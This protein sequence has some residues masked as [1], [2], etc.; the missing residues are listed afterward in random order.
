MSRRQ[1]VAAYNGEYKDGYNN[2]AG[3]LNLIELVEGDKVEFY[4]AAG[5]SDPAA[6]AV[7]AAAAVKTVQ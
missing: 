1:P 2:P 5:I 4:Y 3:A 7:K 6:D